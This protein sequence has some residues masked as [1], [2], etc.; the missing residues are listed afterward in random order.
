[1]GGNRTAVPNA[2]L[3]SLREQLQQT[4]NGVIPQN[5]T[6]TAPG[7]SASGPN[8]RGRMP[9]SSPRNPQTEQILAMLGLPY[10]LDQQASQKPAVTP[11]GVTA[12]LLRCVCKIF[13]HLLNS[14]ACK[15]L[16][17]ASFKPA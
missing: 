14:A 4:N 11:P 10:N 7:H 1:M 9:Q 16:C 12:E 15:M 6:Q 13:E 3:E 5:F 2:Q 17:C 8:P